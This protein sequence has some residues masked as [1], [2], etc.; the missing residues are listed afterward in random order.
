[1]TGV[2]FIKM[3][4]EK[5]YL[6]KPLTE[7]EFNF[8]LFLEEVLHGFKERMNSVSKHIIDGFSIYEMSYPHMFMKS[9]LREQINNNEI[10]RYPI[11]WGEML[12]DYDESY[13][14]LRPE[15]IDMSIKSIAFPFNFTIKEFENLPVYK[16]RSVAECVEFII[17]LSQGE[18]DLA[19]TILKLSPTDKNINYHF[20]SNINDAHIL[21]LIKF[22][23]YRVNA[24]KISQN[25]ILKEGLLNTQGYFLKYIETPIN[26]NFEDDFFS[27]LF[28]LQRVV[29]MKKV[30]I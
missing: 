22:L 7:E 11:G 13:E 29:M 16:F 2:D 19:E 4:Q 6:R 12:S 1:M 28:T 15:Q 9:I 17:S 10:S 8:F 3:E 18:Y 27:N 14:L 5:G 25:K 24:S 26:E 30:L 21:L 23:F 20:V